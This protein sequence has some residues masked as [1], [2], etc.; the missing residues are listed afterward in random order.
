M[1]KPVLILGD[2]FAIALVTIIGFATHGET[3][4]SFLP[5]MAA[6][7]FALSLSWFLLAPALGLFQRE[8]A[9]NP[10]QLWRASFAMIFAAS[11]AAVLRGFLL[12]APVIPIFAAV[13]AGTSA[14]GMVVWRGLYC[15]WNRKVT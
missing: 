1:S 8:T 10:K 12:N 15:L 11:L 2:L 5:R 9:S 4:A 7:Y 13:L 6:L 14:V 3:K